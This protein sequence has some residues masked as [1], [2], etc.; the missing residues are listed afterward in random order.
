MASQDRKALMETLYE[1]TISG[2][3]ENL[4]ESVQRES[5][6]PDV[7]RMLEE[8]W[9]ANLA[10]MLAEPAEP[11]R[12]GGPS[13]SG[14]GGSGGGGGGGELVPVHHAPVVA[15]ATAAVA[16]PAPAAQAPAARPARGRRKVGAVRGEDMYR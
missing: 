6:D 14:G 12:L 9:R 8:R 7:V 10:E 1:K 11:A 3:L 4:R 13:G 16:A 15:T 2:V 5:L